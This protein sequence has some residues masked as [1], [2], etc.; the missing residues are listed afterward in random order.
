MTIRRAVGGWPSVEDQPSRKRADGHY[1]S[2]LLTAPYKPLC[3]PGSYTPPGDRLDPA[4]E[5]EGPPVPGRLE[6]CPVLSSQCSVL[7]IR[8]CPPHHPCRAL[9]FPIA[10]P[11]PP[12]LPRLSP[13]LSPAS[14]AVPQSA[15][16]CTLSHSILTHNERP[17]VHAVRVTGLLSAHFLLLFL[18]FSFNF[19]FSRLHHAHIRRSHPA[20]PKARFS[21]APPLQK[22]RAQTPLQRGQCH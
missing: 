18:P 14:S 9:A 4:R 8:A 13:P 5:A 12:I 15:L 11:L 21:P 10:C 1:C 3:I 2:Q 16:H 6:A 20:Q 22:D 7:S 17:G 19:A